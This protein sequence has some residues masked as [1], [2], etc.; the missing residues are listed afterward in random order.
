MPQ[1]SNEVVKAH[2]ARLREAAAARRMRWLHSLVG[3][4]QPILVEGPGIG[5]TD[6]FAPVAIEGATRGRTGHARITG[7]D[8]KQLT[9]VFVSQR[10]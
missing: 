5:H 10:A 1:V 9:A 6:N 8:G 4:V 2:A 7:T 3:S